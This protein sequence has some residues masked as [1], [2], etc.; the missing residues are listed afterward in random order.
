MRRFL[1]AALIATAA[2]PALA[3]PPALRLDDAMA[4]AVRIAVE[5]PVQAARPAA[6]RAGTAAS[7]WRWS[8][9]LQQVS[10]GGMPVHRPG[11]GVEIER[12]G[13]RGVRVN[14]RYMH[15]IVTRGGILEAIYRF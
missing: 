7:E 2:T 11:Y 3:S 6:G 13:G 15:G 5:R 10:H 8:G 4:A 1:L 14:L 9:D 12:D